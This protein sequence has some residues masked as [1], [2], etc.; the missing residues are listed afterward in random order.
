MVCH[1]FLYDNINILL[2][3][4]SLIGDGI[5]IPENV[6]KE[7]NIQNVSS[8]NIRRRPP[9]SATMRVKVVYNRGWVNS[10]GKGRA[11]NWKKIAKEKIANIMKE[12][13]LVFN[14]RFPKNNRLRTR[15]KFEMVQGGK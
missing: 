4:D 12:T 1:L 8:K 3:K 13:E 7:E 6:W 14:D 2:S 5:D 15:I 9:R 10:A 11:K